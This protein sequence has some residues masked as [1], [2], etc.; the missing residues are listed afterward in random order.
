MLQKR[1]A[2][3]VEL[4]AP[5]ALRNTSVTANSLWG[6]NTA[7]AK[8]WICAWEHVWLCLLSPLSCDYVCPVFECLLSA[9]GDIYM[10][11]CSRWSWTSS[12]IP[13]SPSAF[14]LPP[15]CHPC[16]WPPVC[17]G[18]ISSS[19]RTKTTHHASL[20]SPWAGKRRISVV[21]IFLV[22][23]L[24]QTLPPFI[25]TT[26]L[27]GLPIWMAQILHSKIASMSAWFRISASHDINKVWLK[28]F[29]G[30]KN[31]VQWHLNQG[32]SLLASLMFS[33]QEIIEKLSTG[34]QLFTRFLLHKQ[35]KTKQ[36]LAD[37]NV[38]KLNYGYLQEEKSF[39]IIYLSLNSH[40]FA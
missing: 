36:I 19:L 23:T 12:P 9:A 33:F 40:V 35:K 3:S 18:D 15:S 31:K 24:P 20:S 22:F 8:I 5:A 28:C 25:W 10:H 39:K 38:A 7:W 26:A 2:P 32:H 1:S 21:I 37:V 17:T 14:C 30:N 27:L 6:Q 13:A 4:C 34:L 11:M 29:H 16:Q